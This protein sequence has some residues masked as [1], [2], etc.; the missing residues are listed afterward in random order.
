[1]KLE[2]R[3]SNFAQFSDELWLTAEHDGTR[4]NFD[5]SQDELIDF[6][7]DLIDLSL[8]CIRKRE[9]ETSEDIDDKLCAIL[10]ELN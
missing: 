7:R 8:D 4:I 9:V 3:Q 5:V 1:M 10:D 6:A 2:H